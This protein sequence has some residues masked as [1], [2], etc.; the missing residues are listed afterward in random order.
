[1]HIIVFTYIPKL[2]DSDLAKC[3]RE[4][5]GAP[6]KKQSFPDKKARSSISRDFGTISSFKGGIFNLREK[7]SRLEKVGLGRKRK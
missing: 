5:V 2:L 6:L 7:W 1:M 4:L 3:L